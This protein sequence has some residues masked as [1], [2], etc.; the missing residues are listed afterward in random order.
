MNARTAPAGAR[1]ASPRATTS[2]AAASRGPRAPVRPSARAVSD[3]LMMC[4]GKPWPEVVQLVQTKL[5]LTP[6]QFAPVL[7]HLDV[8]QRTVLRDGKPRV[9]HEV[10]G[11]VALEDAPESFYLEPGTK[12]L[13]V[14]EER[15]RKRAAQ[16]QARQR[17]M[18]AAQA[19]RR[20]LSDTLQ[21]QRQGSSWFVIELQPLEGGRF[22]VLLGRNVTVAD[23]RELSKLYGRSGVFAAQK[24]ELTF[25]ERHQLGLA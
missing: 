1:A 10:H 9:Q 12:I 16:E 3:A 20:D 14:N 7:K 22:D 23:A 24:R 13:R 19:N 4:V 6:A 5:K 21:A 25:R 17:E 11:L 18:A 2:R 8:A 15:A